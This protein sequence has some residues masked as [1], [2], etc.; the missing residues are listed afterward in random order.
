MWSLAEASLY[1]EGVDAGKPGAFGGLS[2]SCKG[3][4]GSEMED[5]VLERIRN[6]GPFDARVK[7]SG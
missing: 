4:L 5:F 7:L 3:W 6:G 2:G 1:N